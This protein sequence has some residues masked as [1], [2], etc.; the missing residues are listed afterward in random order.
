MDAAHRIRDELILINHEEA[1]AL[2]AE[3]AR[4]LGLE[5]GDDDFRVG[6]QGQIASRDANIPAPGPHSASFVG[7][8]AR[9]HCKRPG[10]CDE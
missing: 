3:K 2:P 9:R 7:Q 1:R 10:P 5:R 8:G 6:I 4:A